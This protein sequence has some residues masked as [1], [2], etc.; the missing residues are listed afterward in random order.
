LQGSESLRNVTLLREMPQVRNPETPSTSDRLTLFEEIKQ[1]K[2]H[3]RYIFHTLGTPSYTLECTFEVENAIPIG[4]MSPSCSHILPRNA[5]IS[6]HISVILSI[7]HLLR[8]STLPLRLRWLPIH[9]HFCFAFH[10]FI[11]LAKI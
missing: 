1:S 4:R 9:L 8:S 10:L 5:Y 6:F 3:A 2:T 7:T 11:V